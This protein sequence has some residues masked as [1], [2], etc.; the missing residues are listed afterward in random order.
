[1]VT[2]TQPA[3]KSETYTRVPTGKIIL[4]I[5]IVSMI[6]MFA[7][8]TSGYIV[9]QAEGNWFVFEL[10]SIFYISTVII[11]IS[12]A[13]MHYALH[14]VKRNNLSGLRTGLFITLGLGLAFSFT[15]F[16]AW[17]KLVDMGVYFV[18]NPSGSFLYVIS[19]LHLAHLAGG[20]IYL[21]VLSLGAIK[22]KYSSANTLPV[23]LCSIYWHFLDALW[24]YLFFFLL[25][26]R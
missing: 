2:T 10:P 20:L 1:M 18:G 13:S 15:Q 12:S 22:G 21:I 23:E 5:A 14:S 4:W 9:R 17:S 24:V 11:L 3:P 26:I 25:F 8:L 19:G 16:A 6:M 7:G